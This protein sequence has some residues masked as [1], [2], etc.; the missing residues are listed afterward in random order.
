M[1][2]SGEIFSMLRVVFL[3]DGDPP[4]YSSMLIELSTMK[5]IQI[6]SQADTA[7][8]EAGVACPRV[9]CPLC[10]VRG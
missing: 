2:A 9:T 1:I 3:L 4:P 5:G 6:D 8:A 10:L 7:H